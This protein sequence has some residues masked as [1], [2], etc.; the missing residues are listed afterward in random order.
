[1]WVQSRPRGLSLGDRICLALAEREGLPVYTA[2]PHWADLPLGID[3]R[4]IR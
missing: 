1:M 4:V 2:D 3:I